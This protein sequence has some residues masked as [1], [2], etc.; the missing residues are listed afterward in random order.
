MDIDYDDPEELE[1][2]PYDPIHRIRR[3]RFPY[4]LVKCRKVSYQF[5][6]KNDFVTLLS[7]NHP[8]Q[9]YKLC[10]FNARHV[11]PVPEINY[12]IRVCPDRVSQVWPCLK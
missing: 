9:K 5:L 1:I 11:I 6:K 4:H 12:H 3:K 8:N 10:P 7:Q 2:C